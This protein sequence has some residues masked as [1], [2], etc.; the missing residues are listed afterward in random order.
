MT[1]TVRAKI[2]EPFFT[3]K[4]VGKGTGL[5][6]S[7]VDGIVRQSGGFVKVTSSVGHGTIVSILLPEAQHS[8]QVVI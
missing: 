3:T 7:T 6:L 1:E 2:F 8:P 5:G 4:E